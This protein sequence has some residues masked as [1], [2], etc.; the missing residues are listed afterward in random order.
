MDVKLKGGEKKV[1]KLGQAG[2]S[3]AQGAIVLMVV[4]VAAGV[5]AYLL[6]GP[7][8]VVG[9]PATATVKLHDAYTINIAEWHEKYA[10]DIPGVDIS[11]SGT[12]TVNSFSATNVTVKLHNKD[13]GEWITIVE[14]QT[15]TDMTVVNDLV[16]EIT[17]GTYDKVSVYIGTI[18][19]DITQSDIVVTG[20]VDPTKFGA[21][22]GTPT[23]SI[24]ETIP[25]QKFS[26]LVTINQEFVISLTPE[27]EVTAGEN[28]VF[29]VDTNAPFDFD[30]G[31][32][33]GG[34]RPHFDV[35]E[36]HAEKMGAR[37]M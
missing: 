18:T 29:D 20:T 15:I 33:V 36:M 9:K 7:P 11:I 26:Q 10:P 17:S 16:K 31:A 4:L 25:G 12:V 14:G 37:G 19:I 6:I 27:V 34:A 1:K 30:P 32:G 13:T 24:S 28:Q 21:P 23:I 22:A 2:I 5:T 35:G 8:K 3:A